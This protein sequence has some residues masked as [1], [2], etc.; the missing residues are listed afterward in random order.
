[1]NSLQV[2]QW[3]RTE[4]GEALSRQR[5]IHTQNLLGEAPDTLILTEHWPVIT[6]GRSSNRDD[7]LVPPSD[8][9]GQGISIYNVGRGGQITYHGPGQLLI[10]PILNLKRYG[11]D[12]HQYRW[13]IEEVGIRL[14]SEYGIQAERKSGW[15]GIWIGQSKIA[16]VGVEVK[17]WITMHGMA[18]NVLNIQEGFKLINP[19]GM[20]DC[21]MTSME[22]ELNDR[23][24][25]HQVAEDVIKI[26]MQVFAYE[27][28][29]FISI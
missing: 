2:Y 19:C 16:S 9:T 18:L 24:D 28:L 10:Y 8:I 1:M 17:K 23:P 4:Y 12:L 14:L 21:P 6:L 26:F 27:S 25:F 13:L 11:R 15:P 7:L 22:K 5:E 20:K 29:S 3:G